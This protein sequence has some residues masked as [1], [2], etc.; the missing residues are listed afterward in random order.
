VNLARSVFG[1]DIPDEVGGALDVLSGNVID[2]LGREDGPVG[3][4]LKSVRAEAE[5]GA[6]EATRT[7]ILIVGTMAGASLILSLVAIVRS[8]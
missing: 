4:V 1:I 5:A 8:R 2:A 6:R 3:D 7:P